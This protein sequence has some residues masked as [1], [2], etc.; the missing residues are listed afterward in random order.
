MVNDG[1]GGRG[2]AKKWSDKP[3]YCRERHHP[4]DMRR[5]NRDGVGSMASLAVTSVFRSVEG[6]DEGI[7][8]TGIP[9]TVGILD[10]VAGDVERVWWSGCVNGYTRDGKGIAGHRIHRNA[11]NAGLAIACN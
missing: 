2:D 7:K 1:L 11:R 3:T 6:S 8:E 4:A 10:M 9:S 5:E